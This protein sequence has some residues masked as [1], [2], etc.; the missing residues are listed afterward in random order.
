MVLAWGTLKVARLHRAASVAY[1]VQAVLGVNVDEAHLWDFSTSFEKLCFVGQQEWR[2][3]DAPRYPW[4]IRLLLLLR[5]SFVVK[6]W[7]GD[8]DM[9]RRLW[10]IHSWNVLF[11]LS[12]YIFMTVIRSP[13]RN[14]SCLPGSMLDGLP[15]SAPP[16][17]ASTLCWDQA[18]AIWGKKRS[19]NQIT[20]RSLILLSHSTVKAYMS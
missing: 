2:K 13:F 11:T 14:C 3:S 19:L 12:L 15:S 10:C 6:E 4:A 7:I 17:F 16:A 18:A 20:G 1:S 5:T 9:L 8:P